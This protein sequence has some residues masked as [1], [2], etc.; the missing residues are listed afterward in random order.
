MN[1]YEP[2]DIYC[3]RVDSS[4]LSEPLNAITSLGYIVVFLLLFKNYKEED[5]KSSSFMLLLSLLFFIAVGSFLLHTF[6][7]IYSAMANSFIFILFTLSYIAI[8]LRIVFYE[9]WLKISLILL[10]L[11]MFS[12]FGFLEDYLDNPKELFINSSIQYAPI[13]FLMIV[14]TVALYLKRATLCKYAFYALGLFFLS[15]IFRNSDMNLC[16]SISIGTHFMWHMA[17]AMMLYYL[18]YIVLRALVE[19]KKLNF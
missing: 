16:D 5:I 19:N 15:L 17:N 6:A 14:F 10:G 2:I 4:F 13:L 12:Y 9:S 1:W 3:E 7:N 18:L 8:V 11:F